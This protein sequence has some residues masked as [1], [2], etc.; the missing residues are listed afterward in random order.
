MPTLPGQIIGELGEIGKQIGGEVAKV[1]TDI[2][3]KAMESLGA[4]GGKKT[5]G[6]QQ[7]KTTGSFDAT[8]KKDTA[9]EKFDIVDE[10]TRRIIARKA[11]QELLARPRAPKE[12]SIWE[13]LQREEEQK[14]QAQAAQQQAQA[15][16]SLPMPTSKRP[17]GD[18]Y[19]T[20]AKKLGSEVGKNVRQD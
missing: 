16:S 20:K 4:S 17:R 9:W 14:K 18:L 11:L 13:K 15:A 6:Q 12:E 3:S 5:Q 1:P 2:A 19:G 10:Q 7:V 8:P